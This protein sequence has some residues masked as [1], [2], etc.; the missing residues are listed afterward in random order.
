M[1]NNKVAV[2]NNKMYFSPFI[3][4]SIMPIKVTINKDIVKWHNFL[5]FQFI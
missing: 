2:N 3:T 1:N 4:N 5:L